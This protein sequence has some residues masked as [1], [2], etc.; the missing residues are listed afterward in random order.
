MTA[1]VLVTDR[2]LRGMTHVYVSIVIVVKSFFLECLSE[3][4]GFK[5]LLW[6]YS[7]RR[8]VH[9]WVC[10]V[11]ECGCLSLD[12]TLIFCSMLGTRASAHDEWPRRRGQLFV[13]EC[14]MRCVRRGC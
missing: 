4:F 9:C 8:G 7:G 11:R 13:G 1:A 10:D 3:D 14:R 2:R 6:V 5:H 12:N